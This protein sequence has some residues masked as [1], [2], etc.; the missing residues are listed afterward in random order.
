VLCTAT[1]VYVTWGAWLCNGGEWSA[2][3]KGVGRSHCAGGIEDGSDVG[4]VA[5]LSEHVGNV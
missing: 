4:E 3:S 2:F 5:E 1:Y